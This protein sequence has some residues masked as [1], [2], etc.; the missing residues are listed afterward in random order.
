[1][2]VKGWTTIS[3]H[4]DLYKRTE[5]YLKDNLQLLD[6]EGIRSIASLTEAAIAKFMG[7][8]E[9]VIAMKTASEIES[10]VKEI[11]EGSRKL[12]ESIDSSPSSEK[13]EVL[14]TNMIKQFLDSSSKY[15]DVLILK[16]Y[17]GQSE[18]DKILKTLRSYYPDL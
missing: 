1:M 4:T 11:Y 18:V 5:R 13:I 10:K 17:K 14:A 8:Y 3:I 15:K 12:L 2:P 7:E 6:K 9:L 16:K